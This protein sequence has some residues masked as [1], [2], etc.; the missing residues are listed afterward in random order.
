MITSAV[1]ALRHVVVVAFVG[2]L[3]FGGARGA[4]LGDL[5]FSWGMFAYEVTSHVA[6]AFVLDD[7][8]EVPYRPGG[9]LRSRGKRIAPGTRTSGYGIGALRSWIRAY[10]E[11][12]WRHRR[13]P[14]AR[15]VK[16]TLT[17]TRERD[18]RVVEV[19]AYPPE[20]R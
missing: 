10:L 2:L 20:A 14:D 19:L 8:T 9:E 1:R 5:R 12:L 3:A 13:P 6:Y 17:W 4:V 11:W 18:P 16:C 7:G 15:A